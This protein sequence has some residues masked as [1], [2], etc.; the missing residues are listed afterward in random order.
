MKM[1][2]DSSMKK[3]EYQL[4]QENKGANNIVAVPLFWYV[5]LTILSIS[6]II[7]SALIS[8]SSPVKS[9]VSNIGYGIFC[10]TFVAALVDYGA[11][12]RKKEKDLSDYVNFCHFFIVAVFEIII[13]RIRYGQYPAKSDSTVDYPEWATSLLN[14]QPKDDGYNLSLNEE[15][16]ERCKLL[17]QRA[18]DLK[19]NAYILV[20]NVYLKDDFFY[21]LDVLI[22]LLKYIVENRKI[23]SS[24][25]KAVLYKMFDEIVKLFPVFEDALLGEWESSKIMSRYQLEYAF[26]NL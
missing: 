9:I 17:L 6:L 11:T 22:K 24:T 16:I 19:E 18:I 5:I 23:D 21:N 8:E 12:K 26:C 25:Y 15:F 10:S 3:L 7:I 4:R 1:Q 14:L 2:K 13:F 20:D